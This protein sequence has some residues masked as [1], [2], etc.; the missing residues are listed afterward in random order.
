VRAKLGSSDYAYQVADHNVTVANGDEHSLIHNLDL[1]K[2]GFERLREAFE[3][4]RKNYREADAE[5]D[6]HLGK[7]NPA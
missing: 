7:I 5:F 1:M 4:A 2:D 3:I 6:Q